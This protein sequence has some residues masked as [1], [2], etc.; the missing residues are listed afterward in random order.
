MLIPYS[1]RNASTV[2]VFDAPRDGT[3]PERAPVIV[4]NKIQPTKMYGE[5]DG[6]R[7]P[8]PTLSRNAFARDVN[9]KP[10]KTPRHP[11][12][13]PKKE[14]SNKNIVNISEFFAPI[15]FKMPISLNRSKT[16]VTM[17]FAVFTADTIT[18]IS[19]ISIMKPTTI[20]R[21][22]A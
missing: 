7:N 11:A 6:V 12:T 22:A 8:Y 14:D 3:T 17:V 16:D 20:L 18:E 10:N 2:F 19:A 1:Y 15:A 4:A 21:E 13:K 5:F 9:M